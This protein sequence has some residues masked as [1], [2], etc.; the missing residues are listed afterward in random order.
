MEIICAHSPAHLL[1]RLSVS[2]SGGLV[3]FA[4]ASSG[5]YSFSVEAATVATQVSASAP[6]RKTT[7]VKLH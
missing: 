6:V 5:V 7:T 4:P 1:E 3:L 2:E